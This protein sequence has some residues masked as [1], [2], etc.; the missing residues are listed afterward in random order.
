MSTVF[1]VSFSFRFRDAEDDVGLFD[2]GMF[3]VVW[4]PCGMLAVNELD[5][6]VAGGLF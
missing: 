6:V 3:W 1:W 2:G 5:E 4:F